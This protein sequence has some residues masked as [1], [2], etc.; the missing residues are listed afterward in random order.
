MPGCTSGQTGPDS[1]CFEFSS[2]GAYHIQGYGEWQVKVDS[3]GG[4]SVAHDVQGNVTDY[5]SFSLTK[6]ETAE[7][8]Q[9]IRAVHLEELSSSQRA[10]VPDEVQY[11]FKLNDGK[12]VHG[13]KIWVNDARQN[14]QIV[15]L[16]D[17]IGRLIQTYTGETPVLK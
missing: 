14:E 4:L 16:V 5:G 2:G 9:L 12:S 10:G 3:S 15:A 7:V 6:Q 13:V 1:Q 17:Q 11:H 8:W